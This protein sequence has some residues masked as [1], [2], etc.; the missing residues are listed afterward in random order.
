MLTSQ[1]AIKDLILSRFDLFNARQNAEEPFP[2]VEQSNKP[3]PSTNGH[4]KGR[5]RSHSQSESRV[6]STSDTIDGEV[7]SPA[8]KKTKFE[9]T[10]A[11][12]A[13]RLQAEEARS[14]RP[15][16]NGAARKVTTKKKKTAVKRKSAAK[17][18]GSDDSDVE[19][20]IERKVNRNTGFHKPLNLSPAASDFFGATQVMQ[21]SAIAYVC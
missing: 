13:A 10:D 1:A 20:G 7:T 15:S 8:K 19:H 16:R 4:V 11:E 9:E 5:A 2:S 18:A 21:F 6:E 17:V 14:A 12:L 3:K